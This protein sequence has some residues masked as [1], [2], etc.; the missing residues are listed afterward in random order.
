MKK[1]QTF[2]EILNS[3]IENG[4]I[5]TKYETPN[6]S[7]SGGILTD[8]NVYI[9]ESKFYHCELYM[10]PDDMIK[11]IKDI[12]ITD[13]IFVSKHFFQLFGETQSKESINATINALQNAISICRV[14]D[15]DPKEL[16]DLKIRTK[17]LF[18]DIG[19]RLDS[20]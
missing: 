2:T 11:L 17:T 19:S 8:I 3:I 9:D 6:P 16:E 7:E 1:K 12:I 5:I 15:I 18:D 20:K 14:Y 10:I 4:L 13:F